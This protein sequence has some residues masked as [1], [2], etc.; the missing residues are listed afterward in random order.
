M[1]SMAMP[2]KKR[3]QGLNLTENDTQW[4]KTESRRR[5][6]TQGRALQLVVQR[7]V[8]IPKDVHTGNIIWTE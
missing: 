7:Q 4:K 6:L 8:V 3:P 1:P 2:N 5:N